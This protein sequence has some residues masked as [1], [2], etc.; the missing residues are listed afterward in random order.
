VPEELLDLSSYSV[1]SEQKEIRQ[2]QWIS[3]ILSKA[4]AF[5]LQS[6]VES[7]E[8]LET[9][10]DAGHRD[11]LRGQIPQVTLK[12]AHGIYQGLHFSQ[13]HLVA[14]QIRT[15]LGQVLKGKPL[16]LLEPID[17]S[18]QLNLTQTDLNTSVAAPLFSDAL[19]DVLLPWLQFDAALPSLQDLQT[20]SITLT[21]QYLILKGKI[22]S[23]GED[24]PFQLQTQL[25][26][27]KGQILVLA[28]A[29]LEVI[30]LI[31]STPLDSLRLDLGS[32]VHIQQL[33]L[34]DEQINLQGQIQVNP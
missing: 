4:V 1:E 30:P 26:V 14:T 5:W 25:Q 32:S 23:S 19:R 28:E 15:N 6:Q 9:L 8:Q 22:V 21:D 27:Q 13:V 33:T 34:A 11:L 10:I 7:V 3:S 29:L 17:I 16:Q 31:P 20:Q 2:S 24:Y 12:A 18:C